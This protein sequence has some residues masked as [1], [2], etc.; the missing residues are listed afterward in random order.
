M[1]KASKRVDAAIRKLLVEDGCIEE[2]I[3]THETPDYVQVHGKIGGD[4]VTFR[5]YDDGRIYEK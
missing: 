1:K 3:E 4:Y 5:V 2:I